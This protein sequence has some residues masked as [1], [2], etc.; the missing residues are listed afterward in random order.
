MLVAAR[1]VRG[2]AF[3]YAQPRVLCRGY[4]SRGLAF[5]YAQPRVLCRGLTL[6]EIGV[7]LAILAGLLTIALP[8]LSSITRAGLRREAG[9][10]SSTLRG[11][12]GEAALL[13]RT[14]RLVLD[15]DT[16]SYWAECAAGRLGIAAKEESHNGQRDEPSTERI[17][18]NDDEAAVRKMLETK[19]T[20][21]P[22][23]DKSTLDGAAFADA[24][25]QHQSEPYVKGQSYL[26]FFAGGQT[27]RAAIHLTDGTN[28]FTLLVSPLT[29]RVRVVADKVAADAEEPEL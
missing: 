29:G 18:A 2:L 1:H 7:V 10:L 17:S 3:L 5:L 26:Y 15:L 14:C 9:H 12:Y 11:L 6:I 22:V 19:K 24:F 25:V 16:N 27:E 13:G 4:G 8:S 21:A 28:F 20:F 23:G